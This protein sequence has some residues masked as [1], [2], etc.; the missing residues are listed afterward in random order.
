MKN[1]KIND[2][3]TS[4]GSC[5]NEQCPKNFTANVEKNAGLEQIINEVITNI[6]DAEMPCGHRIFRS[7]ARIPYSNLEIDEKNNVGAFILLNESNSIIV[8]EGSKMSWSEG[9]YGIRRKGNIIKGKLI[10]FGEGSHGPDGDNGDHYRFILKGIKDGILK[11][12]AKTRTEFD[13]KPYWYST[14]RICKKVEDFER[15]YDLKDI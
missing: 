15:E 12:T 3:K 8:M 2:Y 14:K 9:I 1:L 4:Y 13:Y 6:K 11:Y 5:Y 10:K 7:D